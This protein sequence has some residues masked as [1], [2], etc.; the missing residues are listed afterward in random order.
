MRVIAGSARRLK[1][2][3]PY[4]LDTRHTQDIIKET[5]FNIIQAD[6]PGSVFL[7]LCAGSGAIGLEALSRGMDQAVFVD[8]SRE[9]VRVIRNN[10]ASLKAGEHSRVLCTKAVSALGILHGEGKKFDLVYL[11]PPY[12]R[13]END[14][15][16]RLLEE[17]QLLNPGARVVIESLKEDPQPEDTASIRFHKDAVYGITRIRYY[18]HQED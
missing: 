17:Y 3:A 10:I 4:G 11:D 13:Q 18:I 9:A 12:A 2:V 6:V 5:L 14:R 16:L 1:L 8:S 7:D 15:I